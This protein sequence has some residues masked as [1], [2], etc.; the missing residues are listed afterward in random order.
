MLFFILFFLTFLLIRIMLFFI[1]IF[2]LTF[3][4]FWGSELCGL[5]KAY[6]EMI[7][8]VLSKEQ[9]LE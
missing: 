4:E 2:F 6:K 8:R 3:L 9:V 5:R 1:F 7:F